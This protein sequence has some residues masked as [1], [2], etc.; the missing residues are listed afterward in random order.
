[1]EQSDGDTTKADYWVDTSID[2]DTQ[3]E[4]TGQRLKDGGENREGRRMEG[5]KRTR[6]PRL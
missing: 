5:E 4:E 1:M 6:Y 3:R 2:R